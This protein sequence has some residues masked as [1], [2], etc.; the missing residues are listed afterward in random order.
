MAHTSNHIGCSTTRVHNAPTRQTPGSEE[1]PF[2]ATMA[3][4]I[5]PLI[6]RKY[7]SLPKF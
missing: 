3:S 7:E 5:N 6:S 4:P 2:V 1:F